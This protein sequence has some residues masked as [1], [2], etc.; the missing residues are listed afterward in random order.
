[1]LRG[2]ESWG[3]KLD[4]DGDIGRGRKEGSSR[5]GRREDERGRGRDRD[6]ERS[7]RDADR[8]REERRDLKRSK[9]N[10]SRSRSRDRDN[11]R[12]GDKKIS[13]PTLVFKFQINNSDFF[14]RTKKINKRVKLFQSDDY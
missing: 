13:P 4:D 12:D 3:T 5:E 7:D 10:T 8:S 1:M 9:T 6:I 11:E 2:S 14:L